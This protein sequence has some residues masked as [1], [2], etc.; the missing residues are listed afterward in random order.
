MYTQLS[1]TRI[2]KNIFQICP[3][4]QKFWSLFVFA[5]EAERCPQK[6]E[7][8]LV[9]KT[10]HFLIVLC[11]FSENVERNLVFLAKTK[12]YSNHYWWKCWVNLCAFGSI[13]RTS[14]QRRSGITCLQQKCRVKRNVFA[15][16]MSETVHFSWKRCISENPFM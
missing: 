12:S 11:V 8:K 2:F 13:Q 14:I 5:G 1:I 16:N 15:K 4:I 3:D 7:I 10:A 6:R 9:F